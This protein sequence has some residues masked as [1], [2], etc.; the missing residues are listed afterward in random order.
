MGDWRTNVMDEDDYDLSFGVEAIRRQLEWW[1][2]FDTDYASRHKENS[3]TDDTHIIPPTW[4]SRGQVKAWI[5]LLKKVEPLVA[6]EA[7]K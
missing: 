2:K 3:P 7:A 6:N 5:H 4:P 1:I